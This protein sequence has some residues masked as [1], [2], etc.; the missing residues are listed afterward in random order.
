M[1]VCLGGGERGRQGDSSLGVV[2]AAQSIWDQRT[3]SR[4]GL[5]PFYHLIAVGCFV[6]MYRVA[7]A[8]AAY[9]AHT[10][11]L[12]VPQVYRGTWKHTDVAAKE[13][14]PIPPSTDSDATAAAMTAEP[15]SPSTPP[16]DAARAHAQVGGGEEGLEA[17]YGQTD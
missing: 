15:G 10:Y 11:S 3:K 13:Y 4:S 7:F 5:E 14:L 16:S 1:C 8:A 9:T 6:A 17:V 12:C 2:W